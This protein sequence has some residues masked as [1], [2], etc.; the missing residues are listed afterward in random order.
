MSSLRIWLTAS[1]RS[2]FPRTKSCST[3]NGFAAVQ[4]KGLRSSGGTVSG[5]RIVSSALSP[6]SPVCAAKA[7]RRSRAA[8][9]APTIGQTTAQTDGTICSLPLA[10]ASWTGAVRKRS[11]TVQ[12]EPISQLP[13]V[14][15]IS[16]LETIMAGALGEAVSSADL[17]TAASWLTIIVNLRPRL[18]AIAP[19]IGF[20][21]KPITAPTDDSVPSS[22]AWPAKSEPYTHIHSSDS[23]GI[24]S[25]IENHW[26]IELA[27]TRLNWRAP[28]RVDS[29]ELAGESGTV[30]SLGAAAAIVPLLV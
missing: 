15:G 30:F 25:I 9:H 11:A 24:A 27:R 16:R 13:I 7:Q 21:T 14:S 1:S 4:A 19:R 8:S 10:A 28:C 23:A 12:C 2:R 18:S 29:A 17:N 22:R 5:S 3:E 20:T 6:Q 26:M